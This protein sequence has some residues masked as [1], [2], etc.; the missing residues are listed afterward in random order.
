MFFK[1][2]E[3][4][5]LMGILQIFAL[6][7]EKIVPEG[8]QITR[9]IVSHCVIFLEYFLK[10]GKKKL[11]MKSDTKETNVTKQYPWQLQLNISVLFSCS[12]LN[13]MTR[14]SL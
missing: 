1:T 13:K 11:Y 7:Y 10:K 8:S 9:I 14:C 3:V 4:Q 12:G 2:A 6:E 5:S